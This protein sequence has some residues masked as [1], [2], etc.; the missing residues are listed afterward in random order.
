M[1]D[2]PQPTFVVPQ[3]RIP[4]VR[5]FGVTV[6]IGYIGTEVWLLQ[7]LVPP[8]RSPYWFLPSLSVLLIG[9][10]AANLPIISRIVL[11]FW[12]CTYTVAEAPCEPEM[13]H[14]D[15][16]RPSPLVRRTVSVAAWIAGRR[17]PHLRDEWATLLAA[18]PENGIVLSR[19]QRFH[20]VAGFLFAAVRFRLKD[21]VA[22]LWVPVDW[23]LA[24]E[25]RSQALVALLVG[26][27]AVYIVGDGGF[28]ALFTDIWEPCGTLGVG[29]YMLLRWLR[30]VRGIELTP[31]REE[32][33]RAATG[34]STARLSN[35]PEEGSRHGAERGVTSAAD[36]GLTDIANRT[37]P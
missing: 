36:D 6:L 13:P 25:S 15:L 5:T 17:R 4:L 10:I 18:D 24:S 20:L 16:E 27:Q 7:T 35:P 8:L 12:Y 3:Q 19:R 11:D 9:H 2:Q 37:T 14:E 22:P 28:G 23:V 21:M 34:P 31:A 32:P 33:P 30:R 1:P 29:L 26:G